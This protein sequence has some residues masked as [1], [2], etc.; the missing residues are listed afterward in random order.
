MCLCL[1]FVIIFLSFQN[2]VKLVITPSKLS[3]QGAWLAIEMDQFRATI[4][5]LKLGSFSVYCLGAF[6]ILFLSRSW[7][8]QGFWGSLSIGRAVCFGCRV[9]VTKC[10]QDEI[11]DWCGR[12]TTAPLQGRSLVPVLPHSPAPSH[13]LGY[14]S[15]TDLLAAA[16]GSG[17]RWFPLLEMPFTP[18]LPAYGS[19]S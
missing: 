8:L 18:R 5:I 4:G 3:W 19:P 11:T 1:L 2:C 14:L 6:R 9:S 12:A 16:S 10:V 17:F 13:A 15:S 7:L